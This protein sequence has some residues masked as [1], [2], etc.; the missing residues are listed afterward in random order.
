MNAIIKM[1][2]R[3]EP[4]EL[5][6]NSQQRDMYAQ[7]MQNPPLN[8]PTVIPMAQ[9]QQQAMQRADNQYEQ[10]D[11]RP[12]RIEM[13]VPSSLP[14]QIGQPPIQN[15]MQT[16]NLVT[17]GGNQPP[18]NHYG[19]IPGSPYHSNPSPRSHGDKN[20][21]AHMPS[22]I[23]SSVAQPMMPSAQPPLGAVGMQNE[24]Q[25]LKIKQEVAEQP[26][27][28][29]SSAPTPPASQPMPL[30]SDPLQSLKDVKVPGFNMPSSAVSQPLMG[31]MSNTS[32]NNNAQDNRPSSGT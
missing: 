27:G 22:G 29:S 2:P 31:N 1:E 10:E 14:P 24:P 11:K 25:N 21:M 4:I 15:L 20:A 30:V 18:L 23:P 8:I 7:A 16:G 13:P 5:T 3:D 6:N 28:P 32:N 26:M 19:F 12:E 17:I 9:M